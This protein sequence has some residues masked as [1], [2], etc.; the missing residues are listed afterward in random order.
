[1]EAEVGVQSWRL[2]ERQGIVDYIDDS[3]DRVP[4]VLAAEA[5]HVRVDEEGGSGVEM[6]LVAHRSFRSCEIEICD[7]SGSAS[8]S[9]TVELPVYQYEADC[10]TES[11][12][13]GC[14]GSANCR[15]T[16]V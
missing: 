13:V 8:A 12:S 14:P 10:A 7:G 4:D 2:Q 15:C 1:M 16:F 9:R 11:R 3:V 5:E 6:V